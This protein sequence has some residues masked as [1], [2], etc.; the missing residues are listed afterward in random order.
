MAGFSLQAHP[1]HPPAIDGNKVHTVNWHVLLLS[2][3]LTCLQLPYIQGQ[4]V[5]LYSSHS[6]VK[7]TQSDT[8]LNARRQ[9]VYRPISSSNS[10]PI[11]GSSRIFS[12]VAGL[13]AGYH[14]AVTNRSALS[15]SIG[16]FG[17][18][19]SSCISDPRLVAL[20]VLPARGPRHHQISLKQ[21][22]L[23]QTAQPASLGIKSHQTAAILRLAT[24]AVPCQ[25]VHIPRLVSSRPAHYVTFHR[26]RR[27]L[28][29]AKRP[30]ALLL[31]VLFKVLVSRI[32][33]CL[34]RVVPI[35]STDCG[36]RLQVPPQRPHIFLR[37]ACTCTGHLLAPIASL[38]YR[39]IRLDL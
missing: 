7:V 25:L 16:H 1:P 35:I 39:R 13:P 6:L 32:K 27:L 14:A 20:L 4:P 26:L 21:L 34:P 15:L 37:A 38:P 5:S 31:R 8:V 33:T 36:C 18:H 9:P 28:Y 29:C 11:L 23:P 10:G 19:T 22:C 17:P 12:W 2:C 3:Q 24:V 30:S